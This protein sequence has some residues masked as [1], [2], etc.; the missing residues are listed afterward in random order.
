M[1]IFS[2]PTLL[3]KMKAPK[4]VLL[5][6]A[7]VLTGKARPAAPVQFVPQ[8]EL[9]NEQLQGAPQLS[10]VKHCILHANVN[11]NNTARK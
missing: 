10:A 5:L 8:T 2:F 7:G 9:G 1:D 6:K 11:F 4:A 3:C